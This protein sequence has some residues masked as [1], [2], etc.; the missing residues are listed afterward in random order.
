MIVNCVLETSYFLRGGVAVA[1]RTLRF[2]KKGSDKAALNFIE[3][4]TSNCMTS[5]MNSIGNLYEVPDGR[6]ELVVQFYPGTYEYPSECDVDYT[7][8]RKEKV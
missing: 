5:F 3:E 6:Y 4:D 7:L 1:Q 8:R 2:L